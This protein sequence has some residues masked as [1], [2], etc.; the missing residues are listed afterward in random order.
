MKLNELTKL[1]PT[2]LWKHF[3]KNAGYLPQNR[4][5]SAYF[6]RLETKTIFAADTGELKEKFFKQVNAAK[7][8]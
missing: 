1:N 3:L 8:K 7:G 6:I 4:P 5:Q 2:Q